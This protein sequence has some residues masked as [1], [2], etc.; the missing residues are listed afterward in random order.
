M[1][2]CVVKFELNEEPFPENFQ[3]LIST[4]SSSDLTSVKELE[5]HRQHVIVN[6]HT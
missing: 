5:I 1:S 6:F 4:F 2:V 3:V